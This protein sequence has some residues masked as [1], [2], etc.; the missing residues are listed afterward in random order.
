M[1][2][3]M[4]TQLEG[5]FNGNIVL[6][7]L[8]GYSGGNKDYQRAKA[9]IVREWTSED[10]RG[11]TEEQAREHIQKGGWIGLRIP[12]GY[13]LV[14]IDD[15]RL[16]EWLSELIIK[17]DLKAHSIKTPNGW[18][19]FF[20]D[21]QQVKRQRVKTLTK[22]LLIVDYRLPDKGQIVLPAE[23]TEGREW[24]YYSLDGLSPLPIWLEPLR[25]AKEEDYIQIPIPVGARNDTLFRHCCRLRNYIGDC[26]KDGE[27]IRRVIS[28]I[29]KYLT[30]EPL[31]DY[32]VEN[33]IKKREG[34][35]YERTKQESIGGVRLT[36]FYNANRFVEA[37]KGKALYCK[38]WDTWLVYQDGKWERDNREKTLALAKEVILSYYGQA[39]KITDDNDRKALVRWALKC[40][41]KTALNNMV[42]LA[43]HD[44]SVLPEELDKDLY[45]LNLKNGTYDLIADTLLAHNPEHLLTMMADVEYN[46]E[47]KCPKWLEFL[48][49][50]FNRNQDLIEFI[51]RAV[52]YSLS[53][54][55]GEDCFFIL[56]GGGM[57]GKTTFLNTVQA[58]LG[59]YGAQA[60]ADTFLFKEKG[61]GPRNDIARLNKKRVVIA[62]EF[63]EG[64]K[65][66][67]ALIKALTGRDKITARFLYRETFEF[68][69]TFKIW[70]ATNSKPIVTEDTIAFWRRVKLI[71]FEVQIPEGER[72]PHYEDILLEERSGI[73]NWALEGFR[74]WKRERLGTTKE[75]LEAV[76]EYKS[77]M[78]ILEEFILERCEEGPKQAVA[79][80]D[81]Y[82]A[83]IE[84]AS[85]NQETVIS[86]QQF[87]RRLEDR[88]KKKEIR[89]NKRIWRGIG[90]KP[91]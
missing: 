88:G 48:N 51:Q 67:T 80:K 38:P 83:Y 9:P 30:E 31:E 72:I 81:L 43:R 50:I 63:P 52:G 7:P 16:G 37:W 85:E 32:E 21:T 79:F 74:K 91:R 71:P 35:E 77:D 14:D 26:V 64:K 56:Y 82:K 23:N 28:W 18:Q 54:D 13:I 46:P 58:I 17:L 45:L 20:R 6:I 40:E 90:L 87:G 68:S 19:F 61:E 62:S 55:T 36:E 34:Y 4:I 70:I 33:I 73:L 25:P 89:E 75:I 3:S 15:K 65:F 1:N 76:K 57:N 29:N 60:T 86:K 44:L 24:Q 47:A 5:V 66:N 41:T 11:L 27:E 8:V 53:G 12:K 49:T 22:G 84:W 2:T 10:Y 42:D 39:E 59:D 69:P 78:D